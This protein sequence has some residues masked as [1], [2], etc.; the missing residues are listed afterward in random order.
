[1]S[2]LLVLLLRLP[3]VLRMPKL[4]MPL[5]AE[6]KCI[7]MRMVFFLF[8]GGAREPLHGGGECHQR[9]LYPL[10]RGSLPHSPCTPTPERTHSLY[11]RFVHVSALYGL[12]SFSRVTT[13][14][15]MRTNGAVEFSL[16]CTCLPPLVSGVSILITM[17]SERILFGSS[18]NKQVR[19][20]TE[21]TRDYASSAEEMLT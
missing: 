21:V 19:L 8:S 2:S 4:L 7:L 12:L 6:L 3:I 15:V 13:E 18:A 17:I 10:A 16:R 9:S 5:G 20:V 14:K 1:V 11:G